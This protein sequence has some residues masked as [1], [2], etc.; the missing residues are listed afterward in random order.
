MPRQHAHTT[1]QTFPGRHRPA[2]GRLMLAFKQNPVHF[3]SMCSN[4]EHHLGVALI[5]KSTDS[6]ASPEVIEKRQ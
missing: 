4:E 3:P 5:I 6:E 1:W 2:L